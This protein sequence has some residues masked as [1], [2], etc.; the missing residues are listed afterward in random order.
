M[1]G[2]DAQIRNAT[3]AVVAGSLQPS[4]QS[5]VQAKPS[6]PEPSERQGVSKDDVDAFCNKPRTAPKKGVRFDGKP[7]SPEVLAMKPGR[8]A[9]PAN[10]ALLY[11]PDQTY[12]IR[13]PDTRK[14]IFGTDGDDMLM[15]GGILAG[16]FAEQLPEIFEKNELDFGAFELVKAF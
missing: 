15:S 9:Y 7:A 1:S 4:G 2:P 6:P 16:C 8:Y 3:T 5:P 11:F 12:L 10:G 13:L 14:G